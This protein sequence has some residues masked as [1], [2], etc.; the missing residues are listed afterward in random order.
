MPI[1][2][3]FDNR[4]NRSSKFSKGTLFASK[5][6]SF[7]SSNRESQRK[8][9]VNIFDG[10]DNTKMMNFEDLKRATFREIFSCRNEKAK[11]IKKAINYLNF[12][13][14][15][16]DILT[17][18]DRNPAYLGFESSIVKYERMR[19]A[20]YDAEA[21]LILAKKRMKQSLDKQTNK[22]VVKNIKKCAT[23]AKSQREKVKKAIELRNTGFFTTKS[24][25]NTSI[26]LTL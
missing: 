1:T 17:K 6:L 3:L 13:K 8:K 5:L 2:K 4:W 9:Y 12:S 7:I 26:D 25:L 10:L 23:L 14:E 11:S 19:P 21:N 22:H 15:S 18:K 16:T 20:P 24:A